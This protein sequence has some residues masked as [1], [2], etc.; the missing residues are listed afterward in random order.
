MRTNAVVRELWFTFLS[1]CEYTQEFNLLLVRKTVLTNVPVNE[2][3]WY[4]GHG[5]WFN[6]VFGNFVSQP[7][8]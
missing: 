6:I 5:P 1:D 2:R 3:I 8:H 7:M 4:V